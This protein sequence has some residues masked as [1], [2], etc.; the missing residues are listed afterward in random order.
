M[1]VP[2]MLLAGS[3]LGVRNVSGVS[4]HYADTSQRKETDV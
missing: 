2:L 3:A 1:Q 4:S